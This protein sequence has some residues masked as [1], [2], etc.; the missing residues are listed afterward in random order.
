MIGI[1]VGRFLIAHGIFFALLVA[2]W[3][4]GAFGGRRIL[5]LVAVWIC[6]AAMVAYAAGLAMYFVA[7]IALL[8]IVLVLVIFK[9]DVNI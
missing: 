4:M 1:F 2:G 6:G 9:G 7:G 3:Y 8:D 5:T